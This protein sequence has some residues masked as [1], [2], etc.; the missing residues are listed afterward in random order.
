M[1]TKPD[2]K[3]NANTKAINL[4]KLQIIH[5][6]SKFNPMKKSVM[7]TYFKEENVIGGITIH[8]TDFYKFVILFFS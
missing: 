7:K 5:I 1:K 2:A 6:H 4:K 3:S 8:T